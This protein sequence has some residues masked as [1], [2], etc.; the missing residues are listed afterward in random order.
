MVDEKPVKI[1]DEAT[2][3]EIGDV[4]DVPA[5]EVNEES[6]S[7]VLEQKSESTPETSETEPSPEKIREEITEQTLDT[8]ISDLDTAAQ[9]AVRQVGASVEET[10]QTIAEQA[11]E[12]GDEALVQ[13]ASKRLVGISEE[14]SR[15]SDFV[16]G[17]FDRLRGQAR[18]GGNED[19]LGSEKKRI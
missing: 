13:D 1:T 6:V 19:S 10:R 5:A 4:S 7:A 11:R 3:P 9:E 15:L 12:S 2:V 8:Y 14:V 16:Q 18:V 17:Y